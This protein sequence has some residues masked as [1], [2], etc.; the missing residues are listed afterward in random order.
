MLSPGNGIPQ[1]W[2]DINY[3][4]NAAAYGY[5]YLFDIWGSIASFYSQNTLS[6]EIP[7]GKIYSGRAV[8]GT[9]TVTNGSDNVVFSPPVKGPP[10]TSSTTWQIL[11]GIKTLYS[12]TTNTSDAIQVAKAFEEAIIAGIVPTTTLINAST[13]Y[14]L[15]SFKPYYQINKNLT[16]L[17]Q[18]TGP[19]YSL[20]SAALHACGYIYT[21]A[22]DEPLWPQVSLTSDMLDANYLYRDYHRKLIA[23][24]IRHS[25]K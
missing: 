23:I 9:I 3:L 25:L 17:G 15:A 24:I 2:F 10:Y 5:S 12:S 14:T 7:G 19:W 13:L 22:F 4:D 1:G 11:S 21:F 16:G 18:N 8:N 6:I 20:F